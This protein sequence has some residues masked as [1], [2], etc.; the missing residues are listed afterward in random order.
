[1]IELV[2]ADACI[3]CDKCVEVCPTDVFDRGP[4]GIPVLARRSDCQTCFMCEAYCP[5]DALYVDPQSTP[6]DTT[7]PPDHIGHYRRALGWGHGRRPGSQLA[8]GPTL[9]TTP[10]PRLP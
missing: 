8:I 7:P 3:A 6:R 5:T 2:L 9:P 4:D 10:P 1:M